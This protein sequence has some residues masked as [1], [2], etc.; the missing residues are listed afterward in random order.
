[1]PASF[2]RLRGIGLVCVLLAIIIGAIKDCI[3]DFMS[4]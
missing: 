4:G 3:A 2:R 1:M